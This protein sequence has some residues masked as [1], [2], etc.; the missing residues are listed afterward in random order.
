MQTDV[1][2]VQF[3]G[4]GGNYSSTEYRL[5]VSLSPLTHPDRGAS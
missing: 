5:L 2:Q 3:D 4:V 1:T